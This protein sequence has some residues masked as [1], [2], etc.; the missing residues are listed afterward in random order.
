MKP[1]DLMNRAILEKFRR[2]TIHRE[3]LT[4]QVTKFVEHD[5]H[6]HRHKHKSMNSLNIK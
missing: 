2:Q 4:Y 3:S 1:Q 5:D 6:Q